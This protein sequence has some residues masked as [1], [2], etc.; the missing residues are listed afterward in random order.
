M[1]TKYA[2][3]T[4]SRVPHFGDLKHRWEV[5]LALCLSTLPW[6]R[7]GSTWALGRGKWSSSC[8]YRFALCEKHPL[9]RR[10]GGANRR[11]NG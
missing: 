6:R 1:R 3:K 5:K 9:G 10:L 8:F 11:S 2:L 4:L 7:M